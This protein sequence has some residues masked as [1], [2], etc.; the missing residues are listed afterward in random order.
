MTV[1]YDKPK[2]MLRNVGVCSHSFDV[3]TY[4]FLI[5]IIIVIAIKTLCYLQKTMTKCSVLYKG[6]LNHPRSISIPLA[7]CK[8]IF[9]DAKIICK[10][11]EILFIHSCL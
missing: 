11:N 5:Y 9:V 1:I 3:N 6:I 4:H 8:P 2:A 7:S 10:Q